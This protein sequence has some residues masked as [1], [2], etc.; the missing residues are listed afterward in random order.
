M[1]TETFMGFIAPVIGESALEHLSQIVGNDSH[2]TACGT[3]C[4]ITSTVVAV[5][6]DGEEVLSYDVT[7]PVTREQAR[8]YF[9]AP[10]EALKNRSGELH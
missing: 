6:T 1:K 5:I 4:A 7:A 3:W 9:H 2:G 10:R 8:E